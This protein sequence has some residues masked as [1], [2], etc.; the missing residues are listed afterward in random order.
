MYYVSPYDHPLVIAG[1]A[2]VGVE[3]LEQHPN[4]P[5]II[6]VPVGGGGLVAGIAAYVK[7][8]DSDIK[9]IGVEPDEAP[10]M[11][12]AIEAGERIELEEI[13]I[14]ADGPAGKQ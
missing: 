10:C 2:T 12:N 4:K 6:F 14:F 9:I 13:G 11:H 5:D 8:R 1:Q 7:A 3:L